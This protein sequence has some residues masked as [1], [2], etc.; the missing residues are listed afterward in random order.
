MVGSLLAEAELMVL[1]DHQVL[2]QRVLEEEV[3]VEKLQKL[4]VMRHKQILAEVL[5][6][7]RIILPHNKLELEV[8]V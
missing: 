1:M 5:V 6:V 4:V 7:L 8:L 3:M 2:V